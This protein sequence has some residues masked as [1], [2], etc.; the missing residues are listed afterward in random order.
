MREVQEKKTH[1]EYKYADAFLSYLEAEKNCSEHTLINYS[2]DLREYF[3]AL[4]NKSLKNVE[5]LDIRRFLAFLKS[6]NYSRSSIARKLAC[7]RSFFRYLTRENI[8]GSNPAVSVSTPKRERKLPKYLDPVEVDALME[9]SGGNGEQEKRDRAIMELLYSSGLRVSELANMN[10]SDVDFFS[11]V[12]RIKGKGKKER[13]APVGSVA[14]NAM[15]QYLEK[16]NG[17]QQTDEPAFFLNKS[18]TRLTDRSVRRIL[19][20][21]ARKAALAK[22]ISPHMLRHSFATHLLDRGAD[23]RSVQELLG[24]ENLST[25]QI[26]THVTTKRLKEVYDKSHPRA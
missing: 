3:E 17:G 16:R 24:H 15:R 5:Y 21:Y 12:V 20:K 19:N 25:T 22:Q 2:I 14:I 13:L 7:I 6:N 11:E 10:I 9:A 8:T 1:N 18:K 4:G 26:Y 23:L